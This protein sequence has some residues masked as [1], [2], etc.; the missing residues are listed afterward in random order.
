MSPVIP[1]VIRRLSLILPLLLLPALAAFFFWP[2]PRAAP[3]SGVQFVDVARQAGIRYV[4][5][6]RDS[7]PL[8]ILGSIGNGCAFLDYDNSGDL[9]VL[10]VGER[11]ALYKGDGRG[12]F[13][14]VTHRMGLDKLRGRFLG[15]AVGDYDNDGYDDIYLSGYQTGLLLHNEKGKGFKDVTVSA[16]LKPQPW[17]TS[18]GFADLSGEGRLDLV[19]ANYVK[20]GPRST[21]LCRDEDVPAGCPPVYYNPEMPVFYRNLGGGRFRDES[22]ASGIGQAHGRGLAVAFADYDDSGRQSVLIANDDLPGDLF[23]NEGGGRFTNAGIRSGIA[24]DANSRTH[25]GMGADWADYDG[26]GRLDAIV[27]TLEAQP[28]SLYRNEG[29]GLFRDVSERVGLDARAAPYIT[30]GVKWLDYDN[31]GR[32]DLILASGHI[33]DNVARIVLRTTADRPLN[34]YRLPTQVFHNDGAATPWGE[35]KFTEVSGRM[36]RDLQ[37]PIVGRGLAVGDFDN[38]GR[39]DALVVDSEGPPLLLHNQGG[40]VGHWLG[41][42]LVGTGRSNRDAIGARVTLTAGG[43]T[44]V[45][46]V[47]TAGSYLSASDK[48]LLFGLGAATHIDSLTVR[49]PDGRV[50]AMTGLQAG[51]YQTLRE[52]EMP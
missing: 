14:D 46:E 27:T 42:S 44:Q 25:S 8:T 30:F 45:K 40:H 43:R 51:H 17:G 1:P 33:E 10:L 48:R 15:C 23:H 32:P 28:K 38:D 35:A 47:Q 52:P 31:D 26:D 3:P 16:G 2:R 24:L 21:Q 36:G 5:T 11:L 29:G 12:H 6:I 37:R 49:W 4:F 9:S 13:T 20:F 19:V 41:L 18:C 22:Q 50:Q 34:H 39:V 7:R